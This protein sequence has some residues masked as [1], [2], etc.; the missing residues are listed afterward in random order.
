[1]KATETRDMVIHTLKDMKATDISSLNVQKL[2]TISD[3]MIVC[4]GTSSRHVK[5]IADHLIHT[6]KTAGIMPIGCEGEKE[7]EWVLVDLGDVI[8]HIMLPRVR[9]FYHL[10]KLWQKVTPKKAK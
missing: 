10:E 9:E 8:V 7:G 3:F 5:S 6:V 2:T 1:M 4:S